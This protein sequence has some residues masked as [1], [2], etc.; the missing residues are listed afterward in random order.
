MRVFLAALFCFGAVANATL[1]TNANVTGESGTT[2]TCVAQNGLGTAAFE[3]SAT[4]AYLNAASGTSSGC[5]VGLLNTTTGLPVIGS[6][7]A[8]ISLGG[9]SG[10][11]TS[12]SLATLA[13]GWY[14][15]GAL[16]AGNAGVICGGTGQCTASNSND[17]GS[18]SG[19]IDMLVNRT[20]APIVF[21]IKN[22]AGVQNAIANLP[23]A[24]GCGAVSTGGLGTYSVAANTICF[25]D[26]STGGS[27]TITVAAPSS[28]PEPA[29]SALIGLGL[30]G[31]SLLARRKSH[32]A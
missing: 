8:Y 26:L 21:T 19:E 31:V 29:S 24:S 5:F 27:L 23:S 2:A 25:S 16:S 15:L 30:A 11:G 6:E 18:N 9:S 12:A 10:E 22:A 1:I 28:V 13:T 7:A 3:W 14:A 4:G 20:G 32:R 17:G